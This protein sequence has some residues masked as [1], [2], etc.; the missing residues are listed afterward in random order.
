MKTTLRVQCNFTHGLTFMR[1]FREGHEAQVF[2]HVVLANQD[3][4]Q[5]IAPAQDRLLS[6]FQVGNG[7]LAH[8]SRSSR[9]TRSAGVLHISAWQFDIGRPSIVRIICHERARSSPMLSQLS[10]LPVAHAPHDLLHPTRSPLRPPQLG[11]LLV[12]A[13]VAQ[14][15]CIQSP[16]RD[17][18]PSAPII[19]YR[20]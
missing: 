8:H 4:H 17:H 20:G 2:I 15:K 6:W 10:R 9:Q 5:S 7:R 11:E 13:C 12:A 16:A 3:C 18:L 14:S 1:A 19:H